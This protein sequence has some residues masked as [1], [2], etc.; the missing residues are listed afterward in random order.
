MESTPKPKSVF[1]CFPKASLCFCAHGLAQRLQEGSPLQLLQSP[2][3]IFLKHCGE[4]QTSSLPW[5]S[6]GYSVPCEPGTGRW[7]LELQIQ[8]WWRVTVAL[9]RCKVLRKLSGVHGGTSG[10]PLPAFVVTLAPALGRSQSDSES[11]T[12]PHLHVPIETC[13]LLL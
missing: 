9:S 12:G 8:N 5:A 3:S 6:P 7:S 11:L 13:C 4:R 1:T 2:K 10:P